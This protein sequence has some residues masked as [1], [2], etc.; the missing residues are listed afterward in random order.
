MAKKVLYPT[1]QL[2]ML[3]RGESQKDLALVVGTTQQT[4]SSKLSGKTQWTIGEI[5][6]L[7]KY[8]NKNYYELFDKE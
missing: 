8:Y 2:E 5:D 4:I 3:K 1:L 6:A 7:C